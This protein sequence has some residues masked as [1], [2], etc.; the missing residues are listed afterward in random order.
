MRESCWRHL[1]KFLALLLLLLVLI[2]TKW[3]E[4]WRWGK[5]IEDH[6]QE[7]N[8]KPKKRESGVLIKGGKFADQ[9][10]HLLNEFN[11]RDW[12]EKR[13]QQSN[14]LHH[15]P[16]LHLP[17]SCS[18]S[19]WFLL[20]LN[21]LVVFVV[22]SISSED[23]GIYLLVSWMIPFCFLS[24]LRVRPESGNTQGLL[25]WHPL[26][27]SLLLEQ[28][29][30]ATKFVWLHRVTNTCCSSSIWEMR[31]TFDPRSKYSIFLKICNAVFLLF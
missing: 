16:D 22:I 28:K 19:W 8:V 4:T 27:L 25:V 5:G 12:K 11:E 9:K 15:H 29:K 20:L 18:S 14:H 31:K 3:R 23:E 10:F 17:S 30:E 1:Q 6:H 7:M 21:L 13:D 2:Q 24:L 26:Y